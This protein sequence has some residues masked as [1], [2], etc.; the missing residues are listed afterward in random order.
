MG[1]GKVWLWRTHHYWWKHIVSLLGPLLSS[2]QTYFSFH[3]HFSQP[4][5]PPF[6]SQQKQVLCHPPL[7][8]WKAASQSYFLPFEVRYIYIDLICRCTTCRSYYVQDPLWKMYFTHC[9]F[10][11]CSLLLVSIAWK[12]GNAYFHLGCIVQEACCAHQTW[13]AVI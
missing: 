6:H 2:S 12:G 11:L 13:L 8:E 4:N 7:L 10:F 1:E 3:A 9:S 5:V